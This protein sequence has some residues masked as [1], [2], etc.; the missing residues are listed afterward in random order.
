MTQTLYAHVNK[1]YKKKKRKL[2]K[3]KERENLLRKDLQRYLARYH[4]LVLAFPTECLTL[5]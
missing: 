5:E 4:H 3:K 2:E 1:R